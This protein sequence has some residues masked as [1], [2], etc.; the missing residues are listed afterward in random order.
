[1]K[2]YTEL[3]FGNVLI[4]TGV[5]YIDYWGNVGGYMMPAYG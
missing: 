1:M 2:F 3:Y 5:Y 4:Y